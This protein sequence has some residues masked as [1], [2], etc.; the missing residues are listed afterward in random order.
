[1]KDLQGKAPTA[2]AADARGQRGFSLV[3]A[4]LAT[5][6]AVVAVLG[7]AYTFGVGRGLIGRYEIARAAL[8]VAQSR[9][10]Q[11]AVL[12]ATLLTPGTTGSATFDYRGTSYGT[13]R[14]N[15]SWYDA[16]F[17]STG[18]SDSDGPNDLKQARVSVS[19][20][21]GAEADSIVL[22]RLFPAQ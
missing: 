4:V 14:W 17:D 9:M 10:E 20:G 15:V 5:A 12:P 8:G 2:L 18:G 3:E 21:A 19:W 7:L 13:E 6:I 11:L 22:T 16:A 1:M